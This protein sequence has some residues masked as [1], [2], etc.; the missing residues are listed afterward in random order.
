MNV[1]YECA[2][3]HGFVWRITQKRKTMEV[4]GVTVSADEPRDIAKG[5]SS[6]TPDAGIRECGLCKE[7]VLCARGWASPDPEDDKVY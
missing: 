5:S 7:K 2:G 3:K 4:N 6:P 1:C